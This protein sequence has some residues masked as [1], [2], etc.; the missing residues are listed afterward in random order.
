M[1]AAGLST[2]PSHASICDVQEY[3]DQGLSPLVGQWVTLRGSVTCPPGYFQPYY[4]SFFIESG[5]CGVNVFSYE[6]PPMDL[7][8]GD[9]VEVSGQVVEYISSTTGAGATTEIFTSESGVSLLSTGHPAPVPTELTCVDVN[10]EE[11]EGRL[12][13]TS[14][15]VVDLELPYSFYIDDGTDVVEVYRGAPDSVDFSWVNY[16][17]R[18]CVTGV[19]GQY[20]RTPPYLE[21]YELMPRTSRDVTECLPVAVREMSWG[22]VKS[23]YR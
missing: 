13:C 14:G 7:A 20:D 1:V 21:A 6:W 19:L 8:L 23:L 4:G 10:R 2:V 18:L 3:D 22:T 5:G 12:L 9:S 17:D 11:N 15:V 16:G